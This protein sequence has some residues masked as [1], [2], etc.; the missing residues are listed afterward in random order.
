MPDVLDDHYYRSPE[1]MEG[2][3]AHYDNYSRTGMKIFVGEW[4][5]RTGA[6]NKTSGDATPDLGYAISDAAWLT[7]LERNS[8]LI[9][10]QC[11]APLFVNVSP[12]ARQWEPDLIGCLLYTSRCV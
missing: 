5:T 12:G 9:V 4:A 7:G 2:D 8:D 3:A 6:W 11:Y 1:A 10:M